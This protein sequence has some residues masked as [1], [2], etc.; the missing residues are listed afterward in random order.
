ME[1]QKVN[2]ENELPSEELS[3]TETESPTVVEEMPK[4]EEAATEKPPESGGARFKQTLKRYFTATRIAYMALFTALSYVLYMPVFEFPIFPAVPFMKVD[5]SNSFVMIS[6]F[7]LGP[8]S[9]V[10]V[11]VLKEILHAL[12]FSQTVGVGELANILI[13][14]PYV[15]LPSLVYKKH[16]GIKTVLIT[17][18]TA[19]LLQT[20]W[21]VPVNYTISFPFFLIAYAGADGWTV[22]MEFYLSVWYWAVLFNFIKTV[23]VSVAVF[24]LYKPL[25]RLIKLTNAKF[26]KLKKTDA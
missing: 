24:V 1:N 16:K 10:V 15:L 12:T 19:C 13:M 23:L 20:V 8:I 3:E 22:G 14:L 5:F 18:A 17:L 6:G 2:E 7:A 9:G 25:S 4:T 21:S 11:G 26:Q